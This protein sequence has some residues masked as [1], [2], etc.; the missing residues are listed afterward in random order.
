M[1]TKLA[2]NMGMSA[3][4]GKPGKVGTEKKAQACKGS[5][6]PQTNKS[7]AGGMAKPEC[8]QKSM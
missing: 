8:H 6:S 7:L 3:S 5:G 4:A 1:T 2:G